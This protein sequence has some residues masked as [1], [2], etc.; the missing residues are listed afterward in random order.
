MRSWRTAF[1]SVALVVVGFFATSGTAAAYTEPR[2]L[3]SLA[4]CPQMQV[5]SRGPCVEALQYSL[6][7][8]GLNVPQTGTFAGMTRGAVKAFQ[9]QEG[10]V[11]DGIA[12]PETIR[13]LDRVANSVEPSRSFR[14][15]PQ[16]SVGVTHGCVDR[17]WYEFTGIPGNPDAYRP[18][19][20]T[21]TSEMANAVRDYQQRNGLVVD[22]AVGRQTADLVDVQA[23]PQRVCLAMEGDSYKNGV[24][25]GAGAVGMGKS[26]WDCVGELAGKGIVEAIERSDDSARKAGEVIPKGAFRELLKK[27]GAPYEAFKCVSFG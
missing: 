16:L 25:H 7:I 1:I 17:F 22:G 11:Q 19:S 4:S 15:C 12:G 26:V 20:T 9:A 13:A 6:K 3:P 23:G 27:V 18:N 24:C 8:A 2:D 21:Y 14:G 10:L 5:G